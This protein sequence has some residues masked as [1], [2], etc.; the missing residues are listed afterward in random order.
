M[1]HVL[2]DEWKDDCIYC[3]FEKDMELR[4]FTVIK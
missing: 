2:S 4:P 1:V 3:R